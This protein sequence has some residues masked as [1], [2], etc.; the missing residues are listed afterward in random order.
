MSWTTPRTWVTGELVTASLLNTHV[1][2]NLSYIIS[3]SGLL[4]IAGFGAH[5][6]S[7]GGTG[8]N[9]FAVANTTA[10][11]GNFAQIGAVRDGTL[12]LYLQA[13]ASTWT[14]TGSHVQAGAELQ[15][16]GAGGLSV[17]A[18]HASGEIR[19][20]TG[21]SNKRWGINSAG[22]FTV[23]SSSHI[24][25]SVGTPTYNNGFGG[26]ATVT[27]N[28]YAFKIVGGGSATTGTINFGHTWSS[29]PV[30]VAVSDGNVGYINAINSTSTTLLTLTWV[31][32]TATTFNVLCRGY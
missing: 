13:F 20:Y 24:S 30:C 12:G 26:S 21:G 9:T 3:S 11:T 19:F 5:A 28:D 15:S 31:T 27:G 4:S 25:D 14:T 32:N 7:T 1:R 29:I 6:L 8:G 23:G 10:G 22:D 2:D 17:S 18:L 16:D